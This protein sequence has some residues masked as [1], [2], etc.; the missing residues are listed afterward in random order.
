MSTNDSSGSNSTNGR[1]GAGPGTVQNGSGIGGGDPPR[2]SDGWATCWTRAYA[3]LVAVE[4]E[5][6]ENL[7]RVIAAARAAKKA[8]ERA[9]RG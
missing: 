5:R 7:R 1:M 3:D 2:L 8:A 9:A 6:V 4:M